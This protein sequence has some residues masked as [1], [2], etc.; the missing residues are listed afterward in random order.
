MNIHVMMCVC[1]ISTMNM[2]GRLQ[3]LVCVPVYVD[4]RDFTRKCRQA[5]ECDYISA[6]LHQWI[7]LIFGYKQ[8]GKEALKA[9]NGT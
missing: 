9:Y 7:D 6:H 3:L 8:R 1:C 2:Y 4:A 5:L